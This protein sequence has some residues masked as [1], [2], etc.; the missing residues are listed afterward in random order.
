MEQENIAPTDTQQPVKPTKQFNWLIL[1]IVFVL[2]ILASSVGTYYFLSQKNVQNQ[3]PT[4]ESKT[5]NENVQPTNTINSNISG[6]EGWKTYLNDYFSINY[7]SSWELK[8]SKNLNFKTELV[9]VTLTDKNTAKKED[10]EMLI[11]VIKPSSTPEFSI[12]SFNNK[13]NFILD[14]VTGTRSSGY[15]GVAGTVYKTVIQVEKNSLTYYFLINNYG[16]ITPNE[17]DKIL[18]TFKFANQRQS[19]VAQSLDTAAHNLMDSWLG[20]FKSSTATPQAKLLDYTFSITKTISKSTG[21][22]FCFSADYSVKPA[23][24]LNDDSGNDP[25]IAGNGQIDT[26]TGW[27]NHKYTFV[28]VDNVNGEYKIARMAT[29][30]QCD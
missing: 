26:T 11:F 13:V 12:D 21:N 6:T 28:N 16:N 27:V 22:G 10:L 19:T 23:G 1:G 7:P 8:D 29:S 3:N 9:G 30:P 17:V 24:S 4:S 15:S 25:W 18:F 14:G 2:A 5:G 20:Q